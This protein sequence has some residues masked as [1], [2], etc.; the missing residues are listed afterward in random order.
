M[1]EF[2]FGPV[3]VWVSRKPDGLQHEMMEGFLAKGTQYACHPVPNGTTL[4]QK[5]PDA[6]MISEQ[7][8]GS[9][10]T[11]TI[12][13]ADA[14]TAKAAITFLIEQSDDPFFPLNYTQAD[15]LVTGFARQ[16]GQWKR[17]RE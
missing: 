2:I 13:P 17:L 9:S 10:L 4:A 15:P 8:G 3:K 5:F 12:I 1:V 11:E 6:W 7:R 16:Q 14:E